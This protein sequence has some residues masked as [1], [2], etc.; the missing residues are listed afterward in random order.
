MYIIFRCRSLSH[1]KRNKAALGFVLQRYREHEL[2]TEGKQKP[3][4]KRTLPFRPKKEEHFFLAMSI[5]TKWPF[6][7]LTLLSHP[8]ISPGD[9]V[10]RGGLSAAGSNGLP[11][12]PAPADAALLAEGEESSTEICGHR[13]LL[14]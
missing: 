6:L 13:F 10:H 14:G 7:P 11:C 8:I 4:S 5:F 3:P 9:S 12:G 1:W 2:N